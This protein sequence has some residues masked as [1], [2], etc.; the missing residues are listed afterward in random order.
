M[1]SCLVNLAT[2][3]HKA[4]RLEIKLLRTGNAKRT[5]TMCLRTWLNAVVFTAA[6][7][8][9]NTS[10]DNLIPLQA[11]FI[12]T[13]FFEDTKK[14]GTAAHKLCRDNVAILRLCPALAESPDLWTTGVGLSPEFLAK[15]LK[16]TQNLI[17]PP[18][19]T[20]AS[21]PSSSSSTAHSSSTSSAADAAVNADAV[22]LPPVMCSRCLVQRAFAFSVVEGS[23]LLLWGGFKPNL[24]SNLTPCDLKLPIEQA[25]D[26]FMATVLRPALHVWL[27]PG[28]Q[29]HL[30]NSPKGATPAPPVGRPTPKRKEAASLNAVRFTLFTLISRAVHP[31]CIHSLS[32]APPLHVMIS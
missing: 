28:L 13:G 10:A 2:E 32:A 6:D 5:A 23:P 22:P 18:S 4:F 20:S 21:L 7:L 1:P 11:K 12:A 26:Q 29:Q 25:A 17:T 19:S 24:C 14:G 30:S 27:Q 31:T 15:L 8:W 16:F 9:A 3:V